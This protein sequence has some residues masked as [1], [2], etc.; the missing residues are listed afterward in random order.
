MISHEE[1]HL[2][3]RPA[4]A[5]SGENKTS[6][7]EQAFGSNPIPKAVLTLSSAVRIVSL[8]LTFQSYMLW[9]DDLE[10]V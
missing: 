3:E 9:C 2:V 8:V 6:E 1:L 4:L 10:H 7:T 5:A